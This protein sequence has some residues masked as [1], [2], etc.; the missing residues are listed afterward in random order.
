MQLLLFDEKNKWVKIEGEFEVKVDYCNAKQQMQ[1]SRILTNY[2]KQLKL[3]DNENTIIDDEA[4]AVFTEYAYLFVK[5]HVKD[6]KGVYQDDE[7][8]LVIPFTL[9]NDEISDSLFNG[10]VNDNTF[11]WNLY[12]TISPKLKFN[13]IDKKK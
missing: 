13:E 8:K 3:D 11:F 5:Y 4:N 1:L 6:W 2:F 9:E 7:C 12:N 10:I